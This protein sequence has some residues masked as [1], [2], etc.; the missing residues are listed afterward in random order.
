MQAH[1]RL[2]INLTEDDVNATEDTHDIS[3]LVAYR[4]RSQS[5]E[6]NKGWGPD[7]IPLRISA[8]ALGRNIITQLTLRTLDAAI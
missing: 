3:D 4:H 5:R 6:V 2:A 1:A 8:A 7:M